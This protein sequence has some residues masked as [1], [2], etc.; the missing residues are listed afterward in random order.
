MSLLGRIFP[1]DRKLA[2]TK[3]AGR[4]SA[5]T[6]SARARKLK[7][8]ARGVQEAAQQGQAWE[9]ADRQRERRRR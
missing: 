5:S 9:D 2:A 1:D 7:H 3:Y 6:S 8:R 4:E